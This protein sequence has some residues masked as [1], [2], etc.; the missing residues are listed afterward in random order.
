MMKFLAA[1]VILVLAL[2]SI[3]LWL[4]AGTWG[5]LAAL[6]LA[7]ACVAFAMTTIA[8]Q[9]RRR[10]RQPDVT[11]AFWR[12]GMACL[13]AASV[14]WALRILLSAEAS[15]GVDVLIGSLALVGFA[16]SI[17]NGM[18]YKIVPFLAWFHLQSVARNAGPVPTMKK[19]LG[20]ADQRLQFRVHVAAL[21]LLVAAIVQPGVLV[22]PA[23]LALG[24]SGVLLEVNLLRVLRRL[25]NPTSSTLAPQ[26]SRSATHSAGA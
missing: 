1:A 24:A 19:M 18:L 7:A 2:W 16:T 9:R 20:E 17:I 6:A 13:V 22:Y 12:I 10:R 15:E 23:A 11:L 4:G 3:A 14:I 25:R 21:A 5:L 26:K 8:L